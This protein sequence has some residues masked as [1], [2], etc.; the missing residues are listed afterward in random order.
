MKSK[1]DWLKLEY[2]NIYYGEDFEKRKTITYEFPRHRSRPCGEKEQMSHVFSCQILD[3]GI[4]P[5]L[6]YDN[7]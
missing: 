7:I 3:K 1:L 5:K 2:D 6:E 4:Q